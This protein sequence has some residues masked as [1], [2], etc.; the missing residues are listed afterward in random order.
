M[1]TSLVELK[2][3]QLSS[4]NR[5]FEAGYHLNNR[6]NVHLNLKENCTLKYA[7]S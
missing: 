4:K 7:F 6:L 2:K 5:L 3:A 1:G